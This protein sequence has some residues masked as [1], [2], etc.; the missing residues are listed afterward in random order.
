MKLIHDTRKP[1]RAW[2]FNIKTGELR[3]SVEVQPDPNDVNNWIIPR[4]VTLSEPPKEKKGYVNIWN[5]E[6][7]GNVKK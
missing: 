7:W 4:G 6:K 3:G 5:G 1:K 2:S